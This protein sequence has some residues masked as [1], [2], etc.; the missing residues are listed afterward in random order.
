MAD[1][2]PLS[3]GRIVWRRFRRNRVALASAALLAAF[4]ALA[5]LAPFVAPYPPDELDRSRF[6]HPPQSLHWRDVQGRFHLRPYVR[7][8]EPG[9]EPL[10]YREDPR[11]ALPLRFFVHG[12]PYRVPGLGRLDLHLFGVDPPARVNLLGTDAAGRDELSRLLSGA[13][14]SLTV[15]LV[16]IAISFALGLLLGGL[17]G[18]MGGWIDALVM[19]LAELLL[20]VPGLFLLIAL[21]AVFPAEMPSR[22]VYLAIVAILGLI[23]WAG[24]AR[25]VR[26]M[27]LALRRTDYVIAAEALG[28]SR[29]RIIVRHVLPNTISFV[30]VA[31]TVSVPAYILGE[32]F[33]SFLGVGVQEPAASWGNMLQQARSL[34]VLTDFPWLLAAPG[35]ALFLT[36]MSFNFLGDGLRD[37]LD[38]RQLAR[39]RAR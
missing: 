8:T 33:L 12:A 7:P 18:Y 16:G 36:V 23:G 28:M 38:P 14:V 32:V 17:S 21:R 22:Q 11:R 10:R 27:A 5:V 15:G 19:R 20:S 9:S 29:L 26:G 35:V 39:G 4:Y 31:A 2:R 30:I 6:Y 1:L 3:P 34:R 24:L 37:A 25:V 13:Q